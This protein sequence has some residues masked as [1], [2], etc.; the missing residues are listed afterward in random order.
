MTDTTRKQIHDLLDRVLDAD[1]SPWPKFWLTRRADGSTDMKV[2][3]GSTSIEQVYG[4]DDAGAAVTR[5][6]EATA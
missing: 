3:I 2:K 5:A 6:L 1:P 4:G